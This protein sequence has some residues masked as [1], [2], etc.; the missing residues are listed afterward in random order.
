M[1]SRVL[2]LDSLD[3]DLSGKNFLK[4]RPFSARDPGSWRDLDKL[5]SISQFKIVS[6]LFFETPA[7]EVF[8]ICIYYFRSVAVIQQID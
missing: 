1:L 2:H 4:T 5:G 3:T 7:I 8:F 6:C